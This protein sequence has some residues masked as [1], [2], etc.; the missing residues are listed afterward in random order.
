MQTA[1]GTT[2]SAP[3]YASPTP[4]SRHATADTAPQESTDVAMESVSSRSSSR[5]KRD[6]EEDPGYLFDLD[7]GLTGATAAFRLQYCGKGVSMASRYSHASKHMDE[8]P[9]EYLYRLNKREHVE[10]FINIL[11]AQEQELASCLTLMEVPGTVTLEEEASRAATRS[12]LP[13]E[14]ALRFKL[15]PPEGVDSNTDADQGRPCSPDR[16]RRL[17][18]VTRGRLR[19]LPDL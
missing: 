7:P 4:A 15:I 1:P 2:P 11:G 6:Q 19:R 16:G 10:L 13:E 17:R 12:S 5:S 3:R 8:T 14:D 18:L 9:L